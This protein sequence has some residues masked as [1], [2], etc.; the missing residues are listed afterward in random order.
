M[1]RNSNYSAALDVIAGKYGNGEERIKRLWDAGYNP[2]AVQTI[3]NA[4][5]SD[6]PPAPEDSE[7]ILEIEVDLSKYDGI[8]LIFKGSDNHDI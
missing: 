7:K 2:Q 4:L 6:N 5:M 8:N 1:A 3:V